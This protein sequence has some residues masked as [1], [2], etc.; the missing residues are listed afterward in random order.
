M[1]EDRSRVQL[2]SLAAAMAVAEAITT[3]TGL[4]ARTK[5]PNDV[6]VRGKKVGGILIESSPSSSQNSSD[7]FA[8]I[9]IGINVNFHLEEMFGGAE[10]RPEALAQP[11]TTLLDELGKEV[12]RLALLLTILLRFEYYS[13]LL[14]LRRE[15]EMLAAWC[16]ADLNFGRQVEVRVGEKV[17]QGVYEDIAG[18][19]SLVLL[20]ADGKRE[21]IAAGEVKGVRRS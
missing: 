20:R 13:E 9:G 3:T 5:W 18:D 6:L 14:A 4:E 19:G 8:I 15:K 10:A 17:L 21:S 2:L 16:K 7:A 1:E 11:A 12:D